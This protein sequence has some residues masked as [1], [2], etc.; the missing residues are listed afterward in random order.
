MNAP[1][2]TLNDGRTI[3]QIGAGTWP[4]SESEVPA[5]V[6]AAI[7]VGYRHI[8]TAAAYG[9]ERGV[10]EGIRRSGLPREDVFV[11]TK[12]GNDNHGR[13][14]TR[15]ALA[16]SLRRLGDDHVDLALIHWPMP[17]VGKY[18]ETWEALI[19]LQQEGKVG[20]IGVSNFRPEHLDR[21]IR[22][23][24]VTP[25]VN[26]IEVN[27]VVAHKDLRAATLSRGIAIES[28]SPLGPSTNALQDETVTAIAT[29]LG[30][31]PAQ[32]ILRWHVEHGLIVIPKSAST[33][34]LRQNHDVFDFTLD[35]ADIAAI[36]G[37]DR[38]TP[39]SYATQLAGDSA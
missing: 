7:E 20:S 3:P 25:V 21:I 2:I 19:E 11:T 30:K 13:K 10:G 37:L 39:A 9:N 17:Q 36:D 38:G 29:R 32:V 16:Q 34:R 6:A 1:L 18:I 27:P 5:V 28:W 35:A 24:G 33:E 8:D 31:T 4:L 15:H 22:S 26:Q 23:T 12:I 14:K